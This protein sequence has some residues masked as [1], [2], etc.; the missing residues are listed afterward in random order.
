MDSLSTQIKGRLTELQVATA[1]IEAGFNIAEPLV[2]ARYDFIADVNGHLLKIQVKTS[3]ND[4]EKLNFSTKNVHIN[5]QGTQYRNYKEDN[6]DFFATIFNNKC[7][8]VSVQ[9]CG[10]SQCTLRIVPPKNGQTT[11]I[12]FLKD[13]EMETILKSYL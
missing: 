1:F 10:V 5:T 6:I 13:Y 2:P 7:Y 9:D 12:R 8:L 3:S 4:G 11:G